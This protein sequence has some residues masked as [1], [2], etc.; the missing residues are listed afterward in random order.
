[1][2]CFTV[3]ISLEQDAFLE[4]KLLNLVKVSMKGVFS[5]FCDVSKLFDQEK[6]LGLDFVHQKLIGLLWFAIG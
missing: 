5:L 1:L 6:M 2:S 4:T 3:K